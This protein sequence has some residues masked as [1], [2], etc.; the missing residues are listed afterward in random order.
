MTRK[1]CDLTAKGRKYE[2]DG[3][4]K[5]WASIVSE[6]ICERYTGLE[7]S[8]DLKAKLNNERNAA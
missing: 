4:K 6:E 3:Q 8:E 2:K 7:A 5:D 1:F